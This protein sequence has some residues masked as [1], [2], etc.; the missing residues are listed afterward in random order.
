MTAEEYIRESDKLFKKWKTAQSEES[1][2]S[3]NEYKFKNVSKTSFLP[4]GIVNPEMYFKTTKKVLFIAKEANWGGSDTENRVEGTDG[5]FWLQSV[6]S[7]TGKYGGKETNF[8]KGLAMLYNAYISNSFDTPDYFHEGL[9]NVAFINLNKRGGYSFCSYPTLEGY[10][11]KYGE[12]IAKQIDLINPDIIICCGTALVNIVKQ[13]VKPNCTAKIIGVYHPSYYGIC[14]TAHLKM[15]ECA[16]TGKPIEKE[17]EPDKTIHTKVKRGII[18]DTNQSYNDAAVEEMLG[19]SQ[20]CVSA[21]GKASENID[22]LNIGDV[23]FYYHKGVGII[24][25]G[26]VTGSIIYN[27]I[28]EE[29]RRNVKLIIP[30]VR[31]GKGYI[32]VKVDAT[33]RNQVKNESGNKQF[34]L[35]RTMKVPY[36]YDNENQEID[37]AIEIVKQKIYIIHS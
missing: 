25:A 18:F 27:E 8:S 20:P 26:E 37:K 14:K 32:G 23:I 31:G 3:Y 33:F 7:N 30:P 12:Y 1:E 6:V 15:F 16:L 5:D 34:W 2:E 13:Y 4:D 24:A 17:I 9:N 29:K 21:F 28:A 11:K 10:V 19:T 36:L 35:N 22:K